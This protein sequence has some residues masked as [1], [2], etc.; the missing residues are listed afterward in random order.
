MI[1]RKACAALAAGCTV[2]IKPGEDTPYSALALCEVSFRLILNTVAIH[3]LSVYHS[4]LITR[5]A[6]AALAAGC[7]V[8]IKPVEDTPYSALALCEVSL[9]S[10]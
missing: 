8:V 5:K 3:G 4:F 6:C 2:V 7:T 9:G 10:F 1:T